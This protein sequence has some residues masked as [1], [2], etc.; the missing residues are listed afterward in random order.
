MLAERD[1]GIKP[2]QKRVAICTK[3]S[4]ELRDGLKLINIIRKSDERTKFYAGLSSWN[5]F[6]NIFK[7]CEP[8]I[9]QISKH[10]T[11]QS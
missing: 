3:E 10:S 4:L 2:L 9:A 5:R 8:A 1:D 7:L 11:R 6:C